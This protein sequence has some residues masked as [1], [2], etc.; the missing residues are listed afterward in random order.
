MLGVRVPA[1]PKAESLYTWHANL[2]PTLLY[3]YP[4]VTMSACSRVVCRCQILVVSICILMYSHPAFAK[5]NDNIA[6]KCKTCTNMINNGITKT[7]K[8]NFGGG[9][10]KW[11]EKNLGNYAISETRLL[12]ILETVCKDN[13]ECHQMLEEHEETLEDWWFKVHP[14]D[15]KEDLHTY[16]C[17]NQLQVCCPTGTYGP[18]CEECLGGKDNPCQGNG[19]CRG[20]GT[21]SGKGDC[22]CNNGYKGDVCDSCTDT[23][24]EEIKN[25]T[26][27]ICKACDESCKTSC[28]G[29]GPENCNDCEE[30]WILK[31][32]GCQDIDECEGDPCEEDQFCSNTPGSYSCLSCNKACA[33]CSGPTALDC[34]ECADEYYVDD[35]TC[36]ACHISC[37]GGCTGDGNGECDSCKEGWLLDEDGYCQ[38]INECEQDT[39]PCDK[40]SHCI[41]TEGSFKCSTCHYTCNGCIG[42]GADNCK[43]CKVGYTK[44]NDGTCFDDD[45]CQSNSACTG[46]NVLCINTPGSFKC[47][48]N[49]GYTLVE[50][51]CVEK[52]KNI[53]S[54][55][56]SSDKSHNSEKQRK[57]K[58]EK[59][60]K[61]NEK[62]KKKKGSSKKKKSKKPSPYGNDTDYKQYWL[63][64]AG[65]ALVGFLLKKKVKKSSKNSKK[66]SKQK[67][68][69]PPVNDLNQEFPPLPDPKEAVGDN[70]DDMIVMEG[71]FNKQTDN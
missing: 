25:D 60:K 44:N 69:Q 61:S 34:D 13:K 58:S 1:T 53:E 67:V 42:P 27:T 18:N 23:Y 33:G 24:Y 38:D 45:E 63:S 17:I 47:D 50:G 30:G 59:S 7:A 49:P 64:I 28:T 39:S 51:V 9:N 48:C 56:S 8:S 15:E 46:E 6:D 36:K 31:D 65:F 70:G 3:V 5:S 4:N 66:S 40:D 41:N 16:F 55:S 35:K 20:N 32:S 62:P 2:N 37:D 71:N 12:E 57:K 11:E 21:R 19:K 54:T 22:D 14:K 68:K 43:E 26:H 10:T 52:S 29:P